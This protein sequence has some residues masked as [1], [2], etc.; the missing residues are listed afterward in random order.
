MEKRWKSLDMKFDTR[1]I[2]CQTKTIRA[3]PMQELC[4]LSLFFAD[5][6]AGAVLAMPAALA[7]RGLRPA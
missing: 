2:M 6:A 4:A 3:S 7:R 1:Y 5:L